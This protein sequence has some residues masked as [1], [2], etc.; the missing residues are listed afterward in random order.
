MKMNRKKRHTTERGRRWLAL[1][2]VLCLIGTMV[3]VETKAKEQGVQTLIDALP[4][5]EDIA[6]ENFDEVSELLDEIDEAKA[7]LAD[8]ERELLDFTK[9]D[10]AAAKMAELMGEEGAGEPSVVA[11]VITVT[12]QNRPS[13]T[14]RNINLNAAMLRPSSSAWSSSDNKV[15]FGKWN[16]DGIAYRVLSAPDTQT[17]AGNC[18][19]LDCDMLP[20]TKNFDKDEQKNA[21]QTTNPNEW[22]GSD[23]EKVLNGSKFYGYSSM[24][25]GVER[26]AIT[27]TSLAAKDNYCCESDSIAYKDYA[28]DDY[29]FLLSSAEAYNLYSPSNSDRIKNL[30][31]GSSI[32]C[33]RSAVAE[34][35]TE[36]GYVTETG[37][38]SKC[39]VT[40]YAY[41]VSPAFNLGLDKILF[42][43]EVDMDKARDLIIGCSSSDTKWKLTLLDSGKSVKVTDGQ[44]VTRAD[45]TESTTITVPY[46]YTDSNTTNPV[47]QISYMITDKAYTESGAQVLY[48]EALT[49]TLSAAGTAGTGTFTLPSDLK[50]RTCGT[51]Y[52]VY[53][54]AEDVNGDKETDYAST[55]YEITIPNSTGGA[56]Q[57]DTY[58]I[59]LSI[60]DNQTKLYFNN[61]NMDFQMVTV[62]NT[63]TKPTGE[64]AVTLVGTGG[65]ENAF[66]IPTSIASIPTGGTAAFTVA[67]K[68]GQETGKKYEATLRVQNT[69][70]GIMKE[71]ALEYTVY[72]AEPTIT[73][74][75]ANATYVQNETAA[76]L[77]VS[78]SVTDGGT[79]SYQWRRDAGGNGVTVD[80][81]ITGATGASFTPPTD[82]VG[83]VTYYC[84]VTNTHNDL[85]IIAPSPYV[86]ITVTAA[87][88]SSTESGTG[89]GGSG[90]GSGNGT[91]SSTEAGSDTGSTSGNENGVIVPSNTI[92][93]NTGSYQIIEGANSSWSA[94]NSWTS[95]DS[96]GC[97]FRGNG[98]FAKFTGVQVDGMVLDRSWYTAREGSTIIT[99]LPAYLNT[100][101][102]GTH[103]IEMLWTDGLAKTS[104][105]VNAGILGNDSNAVNGETDNSALSG[106]NDRKDDVPRTGDSTLFGWL[107]G[108]A[109]FSGTGLLLT[110]KKGRKLLK[111]TEK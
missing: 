87:G 1:F 25:S 12:T 111:I 68:A 24:F 41:G 110:G 50:A 76:P 29:M 88:G 20:E 72:P 64:L 63:G 34:E 85:I 73:G 48:Y 21:E 39:G 42:A 13:G 56:E 59:S 3:P 27:K 52:R 57:G 15:Y 101:A 106:N 8:E 69:A 84:D 36:I 4:N 37:E 81:P 58:G 105:T 14:V 104:F 26:A 28:A 78:A 10:A 66:S 40:T 7:K 79:L 102:A 109:V 75:F 62:T 100:L 18:L 17:N 55:P 74:T 31:G 49:G 103:T 93:S 5:A 71:L 67:P 2:V 53:I 98:E 35:N 6:E 60:P 32:W 47:S 11:D 89:T 94:D 22:K 95:G 43:S 96:Q 70:N 44:S 45:N 16:S 46:T 107:F 86:T 77:T 108:L 38:I 30:Y 90:E 82:T 65:S 61:Y 91:G 23:M 99:L 9:Y 97:T 33:T 92:Q 80:P 83:T 54:I 51:D 19:L